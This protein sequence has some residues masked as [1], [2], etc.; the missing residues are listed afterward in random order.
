MSRVA[1]HQMRLRRAPSNLALNASRNGV[2]T[3]SLGSLC[4]HLIIFWVKNPFLVSNLNLLSF[5]LKPFP[6]FLITTLPDRVPSHLSC[7]P[8]L[9]TG[10]LQWCLPRAFFSPGW[11]TSTHTLSLPL[12]E[13]CSP[14]LRSCLWF[15]L[16]PFSTSFLFWRPQMWSVPQ[17]EP[18]EGRGERDNPPPPPC[19]PPLFW[20]NAGCSWPSGLQVQLATLWIF[21]TEK[22]IHSNNSVLP[23]ALGRIKLWGQ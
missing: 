3:T 23:S 21:N 2:S 22:I 1:T 16:D 18:H 15:L 20:C 11:T 8:P 12:Q 19:W 5:S 14:A 4:Q 17:M 10:R 7:R 6:F 13:R 9:C